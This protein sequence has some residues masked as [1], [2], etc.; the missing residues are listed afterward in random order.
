MADSRYRRSR[1]FLVRAINH[2][3]F[4]INPCF[5]PP[6]ISHLPYALIPNKPR[7]T[8]E[9]SSSDKPADRLSGQAYG[10]LD[11]NGSAMAEFAAVHGQT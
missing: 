5:L 9:E 10:G 1:T 6:A 8:E 3:G 4:S 7:F 11:I 2:S